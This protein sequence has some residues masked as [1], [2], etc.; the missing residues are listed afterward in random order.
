MALWNDN[1]KFTYCGAV[2][3]SVMQQF[4]VQEE[5]KIHFPPTH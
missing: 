1:N 4:I 2:P 5:L 3:T